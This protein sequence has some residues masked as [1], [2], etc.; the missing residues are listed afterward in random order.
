MIIS[1][2]GTAYSGW[3]IQPNAISIQSMI[4]SALTRICHEDVYII[5][6]G[7]TDAGVHANCQVAHFHLQ[8][9]RDPK[10]LLRS[11]N[12]TLPSD[13]RITRLEQTDTNFH[14]RYSTSSKTYE[15]YVCLDHVV[16]PKLY[17]YRYHLRRSVDL[18]AMYEACSYII[19]ERDFTSF[20]NSASK[21]SAAKNP[22]RKLTRLDIIETNDGIK[23][24]LQANGFLYKMVRNIVGALIAVGTGKLKPKDIIQ[25]L[26]GKDRRLAPM[27]APAKGLFLHKVEYKSQTSTMCVSGISSKEA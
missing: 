11:L 21:G 6:S 19:G 27:A 8:I 5:G 25:I 20:A 12:G 9:A 2:D 3:Q 24:V 22:V 7:R 14:A 15:Y 10:L 13:I 17:L 23:F 4:Q 16:D 26:D 1:Y 18:D